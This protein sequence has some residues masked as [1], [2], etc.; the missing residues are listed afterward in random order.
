[1]IKRSRMIAFFLLVI[2][3]ASLL[4]T[5]TNPILDRIKLGLDLQGGFEVL[6]QVQPVNDGDK[7]TQATLASTAEALSKRIN[8][9]GVSEPRIDV[10]EGN[11]I[12]VQLAG[13][14]DQKQARE[15]LSTTAELSFRDSED[16]KLLDGTDLVQGGAK[17]S[18]D[19]NGKPNVTL[20]LKD[21]SR[22]AKAT[23]KAM[24]KSPSVMVIWLDF[25]EDKDSYAKEA[26]KEDPKYISAPMVS[27]VINSRDVEITGNFTVEEAKTLAELL[28]AGALPVKL[29]EIYSTSVGA[30]FG[31]DALQS[32]VL[33]GIIGIAAIYLFLI[34]YYRLPGLVACIAL[35]VYIWMLLA[36][37]DGLNAVLTLPGIAALVLGIGMAVDANIIAYERLKEEIKVGRSLQA[38]FKE[39]N[40]TSFVTVFDAQI[41]TLIAAVVLYIYGQS[42]V[43]GFATMLIISLLISFIT[44]VYLSRLLLGLL[45]HSNWFNHKLV[46]FGVK[47][48]DV[49]DIK[50][51]VETVDLPTRFDKIDFVKRKNVFFTLSGVLLALGI[52]MLLIFRLNLSIDFTS[53]TRI[54][55]S[56]DKP[57]T[58]ETVKSELA[59]FDI[60]TDDIVLSGDNNNSAVARY[61]GSLSQNEINEL[62]DY[63]HEKY[64]A[65]PNVSVV[66]PTV[67]RE[68]VKNAI[69]AVLISLAGIIIYTAFRFEWK[70]G[71]AAI[72][73]LIHD[74]FFMVAVF[75]ISRLEVDLNFVA[76]VLTIIGFSINDTIV[77]FD[78]IRDHMKKKKRIRTYQELEDIVNKSLRQVLTRSINTS[79]STLLPI[80]FLLL[81]GSQAI[82]NFSLAMLV[83]LIV[84]VYSS[85][86][87]AA[88]LW[89]VWKGKELKKKGVLI[90]YKEKKKYSDQPVV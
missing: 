83:G 30:Q 38:A 45:V 2:L 4:G 78:R 87:I 79:L 62:K 85:V 20:K 49:H 68:L 69:Y 22:F 23:E 21:A 76:A 80:I 31:S 13:I 28:N 56:S 61:K 33:A 39:S 46:W 40:K 37:Y 19:Q 70:M 32:T 27:K 77:T 75:S 25:D 81:I 64:G 90:T 86:F 48:Q 35:S 17:Q 54:E 50:Q 42:S 53:G 71:T 18:Y 67:G 89:L 11:R 10:E 55:V 47:K 43:K 5:T 82:W 66:T 44:A 6:Y 65:D 9:L 41:T 26:G 57:L 52:V 84:G 59:K 7:I 51:G 24:E 15:M 58:T 60:E 88:Q 14:K 3:F 73:A 72:L 34:V 36:V 1:M 16:N 12:R 74:S 29:K 63:F 8:A